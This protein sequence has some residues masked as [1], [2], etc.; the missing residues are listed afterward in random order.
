M[1]AVEG[2][3]AYIHIGLCMLMMEQREGIVMLAEGIKCI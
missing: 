1:Y 2:I 3:Q